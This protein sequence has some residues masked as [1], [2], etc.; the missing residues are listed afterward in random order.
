MYFIIAPTRSAGGIAPERRI[1]VYRNNRLI[2]LGEA[3]KAT[4]PVVCRLV[5]ERFFDYALGGGDLLVPGGFLLSWAV[6]L[7]FAA[8]A[9]RLTRVRQMVRQ[10]PWL[11]QRKGLLD[12]EERH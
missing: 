7:G 12:W 9:Y 8:F 10:Y 6:L 4:F 11:Y 2:T 5:D 3:L 1:Q